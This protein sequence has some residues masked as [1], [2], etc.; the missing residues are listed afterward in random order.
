[1]RRLVALG[2]ALAVTGLT[3]AYA[4][5]D[6]ATTLAK[7]AATVEAE[8]CDHV[9]GIEDCHENYKTGCT[10]AKKPRYDAFLNYLKNQTPKPTTKPLKTLTR[11]DF[12]TLDDNLPDGLKIGNNG[13]HADELA[14]L[15]QGNIYALIGYFYIIQM[16]GA[17]STNCQLDGRANK[18]TGYLIHIGFS[19]EDAK[20]LR[21][22]PTP[23]AAKR[24]Q[25]QQKSIVVEMTP[26]YRAWHQP[27]WDSELAKRFI[28][29]QVKVMGQLLAN[30]AHANATDSCAHPNVVKSK[31]WRASVWELHPVIEFYVCDSKASCA[32][33]STKWKKLADLE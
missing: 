8:T 10:K 18:E 14:R 25:L 27:R 13:E 3:P 29:R 1:M 17:E 20:A 7:K 15:G 33:D 5:A 11:A 26:H 28:G 22:D 2:L 12:K 16:T 24:K 30:N 19:A 9:Q 6:R 23:A 21:I 4:A 31:C 32:A